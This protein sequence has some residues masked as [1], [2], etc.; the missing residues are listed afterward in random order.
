MESAR[1]TIKKQYNLWNHTASEAKT[2]GS[3]KTLALLSANFPNVNPSQRLQLFTGDPVWVPSMG[4]SF[5]IDYSNL[6]PP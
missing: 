3:I 2:F 6:S 5:R 1:R 4:S